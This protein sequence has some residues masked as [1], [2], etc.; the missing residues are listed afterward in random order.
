MRKLERFPIREAL[1]GRKG[2]FKLQL[3][4]IIREEYREEAVKQWG[5]YQPDQGCPFNSLE[6]EDDLQILESEDSDD[7]DIAPY[8]KAG[9]KN[10]P[11][12]KDKMFPMQWLET[13]GFRLEAMRYFPYR[14]RE[15]EL[16]NKI[17]N[18]PKANFRHVFECE[19][20]IK[21]Q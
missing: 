16:P 12:L 3:D 7:A 13:S 20:K 11:S 8:I 15:G 17:L 14:N 4:S 2:A 6:S 1:V 5:Q 19:P 18:D 21:A 10:D 9:L